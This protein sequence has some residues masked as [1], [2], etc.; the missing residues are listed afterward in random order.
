MQMIKCHCFQWKLF[1]YSFDH[2]L[3]LIMEDTKTI[4]S[5][6]VKSMPWKKIICS[7]NKASW[8]G[9]IFYIIQ[10]RLCLATLGLDS[11][12]GKPANANGDQT[13]ILKVTW[14]QRDMLKYLSSFYGCLLLHQSQTWLFIYSKCFWSLILNKCTLI[15]RE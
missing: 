1:K 9:D 4:T 10:H 14:F 5:V 2:F 8:S 7:I 6:K 11:K 13:Y 3:H 12:T 15:I